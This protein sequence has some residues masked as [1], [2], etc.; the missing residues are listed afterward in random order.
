MTFKELR[1]RAHKKIDE[2]AQIL[3]IKEGT[4]RKYESSEKTPS[5]DILLKMKSFYNCSDSEI[6]E[7]LKFNK[8]ERRAKYE[9]KNI[10][11]NKEFAG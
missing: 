1:I 3:G 2:S 11:I 5:T 9:R 8:K 7:A 6:I 4:L 10:R